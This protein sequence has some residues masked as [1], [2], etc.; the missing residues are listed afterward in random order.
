MD[1]ACAWAA[2]IS[3]R[4]VTDFD[5]GITTRALTELRPRNGAGQSIS[6]SLLSTYVRT[7]CPSAGDGRDH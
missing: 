6:G 7:L 5:P 3:A 4:L 1:G 2:S